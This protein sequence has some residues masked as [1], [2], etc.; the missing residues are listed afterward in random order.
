M[1]PKIAVAAAFTSLAAAGILQ[2]CINISYRQDWL[3]ADCLTGDGTGTRINS[4]VYIENKFTNNDA[5]LRWQ[6]NGGYR[7]S[8]RGCTMVGTIFSCSCRPNFLDYRQTSINIEEHIG[9]YKGYLL[10]NLTGPPQIPSKSSTVPVPSD[11]SYTL[12]VGSTNC[13]SPENYDDCDSTKPSARPADCGEGV[14]AS[15]AVGSDCLVNRWYFPWEVYTSFQSIN[16]APAVSNAWSFTVY[17]GYQCNGAVLGKAAPGT[18]SKYSKYGVGVKVEP[19]F[20][21]DWRV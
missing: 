2:E 14:L 9:V 5:N 7:L 6:A 4:A 21:G 19:L 15:S 13:T 11:F 20:N 3:V 8:C 17:D 1:L 10:S 16:P 12:R 18:C